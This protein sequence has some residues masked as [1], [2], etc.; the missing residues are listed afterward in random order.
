MLKVIG[1]ALAIYVL[2]MA[3]GLFL[4]QTSMRSVG[5]VILGFGLIAGMIGTPL[6]LLVVSRKR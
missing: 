2:V 1:A 3:I 4:C 6:C 5:E